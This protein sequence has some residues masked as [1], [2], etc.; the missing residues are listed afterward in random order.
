MENLLSLLIAVMAGVIVSAPKDD[1]VQYCSLSV[2]LSTT[3]FEALFLLVFQ[4]TFIR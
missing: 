2:I 1:V 4:S 3:S